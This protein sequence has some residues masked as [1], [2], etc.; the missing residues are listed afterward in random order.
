MGH[1]IGDAL[2]EREA[3]AKANFGNGDASERLLADDD[4][5]L[6]PCFEPGI[7]QP[8][9]ARVD[10]VGDD[11]GEQRELV[12]PALNELVAYGLFGEI[13]REMHSSAGPL[14]LEPDRDTR[15][16]GRNRCAADEP[17]AE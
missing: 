15:A 4:I 8:R 6:A 11:V 16:A 2:S 10:L 1:E 5:G 7:D 17:E 9:G 13:V 14:R 3:I 12:A